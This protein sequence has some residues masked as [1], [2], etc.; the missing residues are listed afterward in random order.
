MV[1]MLGLV[2]LRTPMVPM[3]GLVGGDSASIAGPCLPAIVRT[4]MVPIL[5]AGACLPARPNLTYPYPKQS[6]ADGP[7]AGAC[8]WR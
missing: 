5:Y 6:K 3:P 2:F 7:Y 4:P 8:G 1:P